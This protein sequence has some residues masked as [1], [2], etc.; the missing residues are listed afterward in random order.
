[1]KKFTKGLITGMGIGTV[2]GLGTSLITLVMIDKES[3][4][5]NKEYEKNLRELSAYLDTEEG[6]ANRPLFRDVINELTDIGEI[7]LKE[8][9][10]NLVTAMKVN[11]KASNQLKGFLNE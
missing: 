9:L 1:M 2:A 5:V 6:K 10:N 8:T 11:E 7:R 3:E 4:R